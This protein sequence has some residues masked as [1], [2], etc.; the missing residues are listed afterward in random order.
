M[1][2]SGG[3]L[4][5][6][7]WEKYFSIYIVSCERS[8]RRYS[9]ILLSLLQTSYDIRRWLPIPIQTR[10]F[11]GINF[12]PP[13]PSLKTVFRPIA[14]VAVDTRLRRQIWWQ[15]RRIRVSQQLSPANGEERSESDAGK[16]GRKLKN[17][18]VEYTEWHIDMHIK[19]LYG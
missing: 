5:R 8:S 1:P 13:E 4:I 17:G 11:L 10:H 7:F 12:R 18:T 3:W 2:E 6:N 9:I 16:A 14:L 19:V 15:V